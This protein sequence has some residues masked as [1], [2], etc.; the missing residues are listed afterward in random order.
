MTTETA[1][2]KA[3]FY[4]GSCCEAEN[5]KALGL[6]R[7]AGIPLAT[8]MVKELEDFP[9]I[10]WG[11]VRYEGLKRIAE[12]VEK[13]KKGDVPPVLL[14]MNRTNIGVRRA[15][16]ENRI[17]QAVALAQV[18]REKDPKLEHAF[19]PEVAGKILEEGRE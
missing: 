12:F 5:R 13:W 14:P 1:E 9:H 4:E 19:T 3:W 17:D 11:H 7:S 15:M 10:E 16:R 2:T 8:I 18:I 6:L